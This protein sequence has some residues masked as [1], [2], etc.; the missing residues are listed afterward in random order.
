MN[1]DLAILEILSSKSYHIS[2]Q[3]FK[4]RKLKENGVKFDKDSRN[5]ETSLRIDRLN[6]ELG[7]FKKDIPSSKVSSSSDSLFFQGSLFD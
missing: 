6:D 1:H 3:W 2:K 7:G 5:F 4:D